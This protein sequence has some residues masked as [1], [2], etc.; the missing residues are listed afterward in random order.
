MVGSRLAIPLPHRRMTA[1]SF[2]L[3]RLLFPALGRLFMAMPFR[4]HSLFLDSCSPHLC[5][6]VILRTE[7]FLQLVT[8]QLLPPSPLLLKSSFLKKTS[9]P[10]PY[11][12]SPCPFTLLQ[13][14]TALLPQNGFSNTLAVSPFPRRHF[15]TFSPRRRPTDIFP[16]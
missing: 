5:R 9:V 16:E 14:S 10:S 7:S 13:Q 11:L 3:F 4:R 1:A 12:F 15:S 8:K 6:I 2:H